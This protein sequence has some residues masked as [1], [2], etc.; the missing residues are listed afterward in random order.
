MEVLQKGTGGPDDKAAIFTCR[1]CGAKLKARK[2]EGHYVSD[3][4]DGDFVEMRCP[5][6]SHLTSVA[7]TLFQL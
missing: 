6:C 3:W 7:A 1:K 2:S 5:E 4:K